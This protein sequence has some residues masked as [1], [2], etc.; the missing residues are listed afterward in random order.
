MSRNQIVYVA[1]SFVL[2]VLAFTRALDGIGSERAEEALQ[3]ALATYAIARALNGVISVAQGTELAIEPAGIGVIL[4]PGEILDPINDL[5]ERFSWVMLAS[6]ASLG[7]INVLLAISAWV[8]LSIV[9]SVGLLLLAY[10]VWRGKTSAGYSA[11]L[12]FKLVIVLVILRFSAPVVVILND[13]IYQQFLSTRYQTAISELDETRTRVAEINS[14]QNVSTDDGAERSLID[15]ARA[16][17]ESTA[18]HIKRKLDMEQNMADLND[19]A[20]NASRAAIDLIVIF[21][22]QTILLPLVFIWIIWYILKQVINR[23][24]EPGKLLSS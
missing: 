15:Q 1:L 17:Y 2:I 11:S 6:S 5:I 16:L 24:L 13:F 9:M 14:E 22:F 8:W 20:T 21:I 12:M 10:L 19:T 4:T 23:H 18:Q 7:V 3:R